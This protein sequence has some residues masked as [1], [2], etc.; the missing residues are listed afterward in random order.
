M[1]YLPGVRYVADELDAV[2]TTTL[3]PLALANHPDIEA[4]WQ[5]AYAWLASRTA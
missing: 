2:I 3:L 4:A 5:A 1:V